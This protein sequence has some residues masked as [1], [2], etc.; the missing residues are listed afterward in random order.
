M[1]PLDETAAGVFVVSVTP[2]TESGELDL[3][4][5]DRLV[6]Y[7][8]AVG[9]RGITLLGMMGEAQKLT[10]T[11]SLTFVRRVAKRVGGTV[12]IVVGASSPGFAQ[13]REL[14]KSARD[15]GCTA[16]MIAPPSHLR[17]DAQI[18][19]YFSAVA[20]NVSELPF[21]L[22]D[23]PLVTNVQIAPAVLISVVRDI[24]ACVM[25]KHEDWPGLAKISALRKASDAGEIRRISVLAGNGGL[26]LAEELG[27]GV[28]GA[29]TGFAYP[30]MMVSVCAAHAA[31]QAERARDLMDAYLPLMRYEQ[32]PG[33]GLAIRKYV[34]AKRG[35]IG[36]A[37]VR[38]PGMP[39]SP[40][41][42]SE[43]DL[44]IERQTRRLREIG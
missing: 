1:I 4:S 31:G 12:P 27:R 28:D 41:E 7:Y 18:L 44:L 29:M 19:G 17:T 11:E 13:M 21:V 39:L 38:N 35:W 26:F 24:P 34:L 36:S 23:F 32:Q 40:M 6:D 22:Q 42:V 33:I 5:T 3:E 30:E 15:E 9:V 20:E 10:L 25:L 14:S 16:V 8:L 37:K 2:F 43:V